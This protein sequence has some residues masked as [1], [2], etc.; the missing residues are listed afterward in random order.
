MQRLLVYIALITAVMITGG[1]GSESSQSVNEPPPVVNPPPTQ[2]PQTPGL[3]VVYRQALVHEFF[4]D[5]QAPPY[6]YAGVEN[7]AGVVWFNGHASIPFDLWGNGLPDVYVSFFKGYGTG[8]D[9]RTIPVVL[10]NNNGQLSYATDETELNQ[11]V[12]GARRV[13]TFGEEPSDIGRGFFVVN[14][15]TGD[16]NFGEANLILA[17]DPPRFANERLP[18]FT[19]SGITGKSNTVNVHAMAGGDLNGNGRTDFYVA[20]WGGYNDDFS[21]FVDSSYYLI[22]DAD[23]QWRLEFDSFLDEIS[24]FDN[25]QGDYRFSTILD[26]H[27]ADVNNNGYGDLIVGAEQH[28]PDTIAT[29]IYFNQGPDAQDVP[30]FSIEDR[31]CVNNE[32]FP[33]DAGNNSHLATWSAD[34]DNNGYQDIIAMYTQRDPYYR[35]YKFLV[36]KNDQGEFSIDHDAM[37]HDLSLPYDDDAWSDFFNVADVNG[38]GFPDFIG[39]ANG[40]VRLW[41][42]DTHG[43]LVEVKVESD[44]DV[45]LHE[46]TGW[47]DF[48]NGVFAAVT[49]G[50]DCTAVDDADKCAERRVWFSQV[51]LNREVLSLEEELEIQE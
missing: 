29:C 9:T 8:L 4:S 13:A 24:Y 41:L 21:I 1:C 51:E 11:K 49:Y 50:F 42:N 37:Q 43:R 6:E 15:E 20:D 27:I 40:R 33:F 7:E 16:H 35:E 19:M 18:E 26:V 17:G 22:Q 48:G 31:W 23:G 36:L 47:A 39:T 44:V 10:R 3:K 46:A 12:M 14:H 2:P 28:A 25:N 30:Q 45:Y 32:D 38:N 5:E 34:L